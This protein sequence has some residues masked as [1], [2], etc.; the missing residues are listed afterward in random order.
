LLP[1]SETMLFGG[2]PFIADMTAHAVCQEP[3][4]AIAMRAAF[5]QRL[6]AALAVLGQVEAIICHRPQ[7]GMFLLVDI[8]R[9]DLSGEA[10]AMKLLEE[11]EVAVMPGEAFGAQTAGF[12]RI[13]LTVPQEAITEAAHR[14]RRFVHRLTS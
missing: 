8:K 2:Q 5:Q 13:S 1:L 6:E 9:T 11:E 3:L 7:A 4:A 14:I 12:I 10:F